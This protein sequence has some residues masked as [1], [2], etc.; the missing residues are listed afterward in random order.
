MAIDR[1]D[2]LSIEQESYQYIMIYHNTMIYLD[3]SWHIMTFCH[4]N[5]KHCF[6]AKARNYGIFDAKIYTSYDTLWWWWSVI[7]TATKM[8]MSQWWQGWPQ[9]QRLDREEGV[10]EAAREPLRW[11]V[12][13]GLQVILCQS[14]PFS[15]RLEICR[16]IRHFYLWLLLITA[17]ILLHPSLSYFSSALMER[18]LRRPAWELCSSKSLRDEI[19][20][21]TMSEIK[22]FFLPGRVHFVSANKDEV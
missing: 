6:V 13:T 17:F 15:T 22:S 19:N 11:S 18:L 2:W 14:S 4:R 3:I 10:R 9:S 8:M 1:A 12:E 20:Q 7:T 21:V 5:K 16:K